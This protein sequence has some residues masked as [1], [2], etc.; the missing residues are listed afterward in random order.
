M[1]TPDHGSQKVNLTPNL[2]F[3]VRYAVWQMG[4]LEHLTN[5]PFMDTM[6]RIGADL[7]ILYR[8]P[9][10]LVQ[11]F[12]AGISKDP[13]YKKNS[14]QQL[15]EVVSDLFDKYVIEDHEKMTAVITAVGQAI[16]EAMQKV[17]KGL[18]IDKIKEGEGGDVPLESDPP[19]PASEVE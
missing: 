6:S 16:G 1:T 17:S 4:V 9:M 13:R 11:L 14:H 5:E 10:L 3:T 18:G 12:A 19:L 15:L 8:S 7:T 2:E